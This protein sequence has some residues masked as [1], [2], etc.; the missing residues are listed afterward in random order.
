MTKEA[1]IA[2]T[3]R[4]GAEV[5]SAGRFDVL[6]EILA[7][8]F[9]DHDPAPDQG[10]GIEGLKGFFRTMRTAFPD[11]KGEVVEMTATDDHVAMRYTLSGTHQGEYQ[12]VAPTGKSFR[13]AALQLGRYENGQCVERWGS[14]DELGMLKQLGILEQ[15][16]EGSKEKSGVLGALG[17]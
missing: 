14:T 2:A 5:A 9:V 17:F 10:P 11:L 13:V 12:G 8:S 3:K 15:V 1:N 4:W 6:D 16:A 7:P